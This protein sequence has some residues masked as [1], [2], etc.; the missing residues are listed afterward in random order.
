MLFFSPTWNLCPRALS[1]V[2]FSLCTPSLFDLITFW[3]HAASSPHLYLDLVSSG[4]QMDIFVGIS[5]RNCKAVQAQNRT[6]ISSPKPALSHLPWFF[7]LVSD[8]TQVLVLWVLF[9]TF[10][11]IPVTLL[12]RGPIVSFLDYSKTLITGRPKSS[13]LPSE[14]YTA[15]RK[16]LRHKSSRVT[17]CFKVWVIPVVN[18]NIFR[19]CGHLISRA[20]HP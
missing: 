13:L 6:V 2:S 15:A 4:F 1:K 20:L 12:F 18:I 19:S 3:H 16:V 11:S 9:R 7:N 10:R 5:C 8:P 14:L 17:I